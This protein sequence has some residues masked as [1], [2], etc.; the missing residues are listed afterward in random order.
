MRNWT[1][2]QTNLEHEKICYHGIAIKPR[3][4]VIKPSPLK[5]KFI[6]G[7]YYYTNNFW[8][9]TIFIFMK[10]TLINGKHDWSVSSQASDIT[11]MKLH[12]GCACTCNTR[13][14]EEGW[15]R[16][17]GIVIGKIYVMIIHHCAYRKCYHP[18][19]TSLLTGTSAFLLI[20]CINFT[21][22]NGAFAFNTKRESYTVVMRY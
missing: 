18:G 12:I 13:V 2:A 5:K 3:T 15:G 17:G 1:A 11:W 8:K 14:Y 21:R 22:C 19:C 10:I 20:D 16:K 4:T 7:C 9:I 6:I